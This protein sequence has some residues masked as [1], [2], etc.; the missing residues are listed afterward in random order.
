MTHRKMKISCWRRDCSSLATP[1]H[2][3]KKK[4]VN[5]DICFQC[6]NGHK[7]HTDA[8]MTR[9]SHCDCHNEKHQHHRIGWN[10]R[11]YLAGV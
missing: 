11:V 8:T 5:R 9:T 3:G 7:F 4:G 10:D 1:V 6:E 2:Q